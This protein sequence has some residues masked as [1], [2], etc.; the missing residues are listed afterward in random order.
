[1]SELKF[2]YVTDSDGSK[3]IY[4]AT[5]KSLGY[6]YY[7]VDNQ[8]K[9]VIVQDMGSYVSRCAWIPPEAMPL[10]KQLGNRPYEHKPFMQW[11]S[12]S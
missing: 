3:L 5:F 6:T 8:N 11:L 4:V 10:L 2:G 12:R 9:W 1:M 7:I